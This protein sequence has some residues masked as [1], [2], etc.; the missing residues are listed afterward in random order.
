MRKIYLI[1]GLVLVL[2]LSIFFVKRNVIFYGDT[3][4]VYLNSCQEDVAKFFAFSRIDLLD[5]CNCTYD[6]FV[7]LMGKNKMK[8]FTKV[9]LENDKDKTTKFLIKNKIDLQKFDANFKAC[10]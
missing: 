1:I 4:Q 7:Q 9:L 3:K 2:V 10:F 8:S 5:T 6:R